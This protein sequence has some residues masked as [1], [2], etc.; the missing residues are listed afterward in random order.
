MYWYSCKN[1]LEPR[2]LAGSKNTHHTRH[3]HDLKSE[4]T[5]NYIGNKKQPQIDTC[6]NA[7]KNIPLDIAVRY[8][9]LRHIDD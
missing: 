8:G 2:Y 1:N 7:I 4:F 6:K 9:L 5:S 3:S